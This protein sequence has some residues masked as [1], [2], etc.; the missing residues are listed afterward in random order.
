MSWGLRDSYL[1]LDLYVIRSWSSDF[2]K[3]AYPHSQSSPWISRIMASRWGSLSFLQ[4]LSAAV[5]R[6][7][8]SFL[9]PS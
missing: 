2:L 5:A 3:M 8:S 4:S 1:P 9:V 7:S 6:F